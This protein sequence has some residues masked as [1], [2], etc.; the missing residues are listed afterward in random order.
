LS[1]TTSYKDQTE[2]LALYE[3]HGIKEYWVINPDARY[4]MI[5]RLEGVKHSKPEYLTE[6]DIIENRVLEGLKIELSEL[7]A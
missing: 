5:Y 2:K 4:V 6:N 1:P 7:W 3:K